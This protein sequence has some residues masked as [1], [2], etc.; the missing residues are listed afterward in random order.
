M[1][2]SSRA[3]SASAYSSSFG[4][5]DADDEEGE[6]LIQEME[7]AQ[8]GQRRSFLHTLQNGLNVN[9]NFREE[10]VDD[11]FHSTVVTNIVEV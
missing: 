7:R 1:E 9:T 5:T 3:Q 4:S 11:V 2:A 10:L 6:V 8:Q